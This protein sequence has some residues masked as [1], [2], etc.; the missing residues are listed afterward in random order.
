MR[1]FLPYLL[2]AVGALI[3]FM[4]FVISLGTHSIEPTP[5]IRA[6]ERA[7]ANR[8]IICAAGGVLLFVT[9]TVWIVIRWFSRRFSRKSIT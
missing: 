4:F 3:A 1:R 8:F 9:G 2:C 5:Q 7:Q 6:L